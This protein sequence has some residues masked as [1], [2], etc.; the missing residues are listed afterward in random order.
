MLSKYFL[1]VV[2]LLIVLFEKQDKTVKSTFWLFHLCDGEKWQNR[3]NMVEKKCENPRSAF[4]P[5]FHFVR[6]QPRI[7]ISVHP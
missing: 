3:P 6:L 2:L 4:G 7:F 1:I 5:V